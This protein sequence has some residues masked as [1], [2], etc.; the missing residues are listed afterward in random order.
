MMQ[1]FLLSNLDELPIN[2]VV[3]IDGTAVQLHVGS[4]GAI[5][6]AELIS[7]F[8]LI[9]MT[10]YL[11]LGFSNALEFEAG[12]AFDSARKKFVLSHWLP[13]VAN[14]ASAAAALEL[15]LNQVDVCQS[16]HKVP[17]PSVIKEP[18]RQRAEIRLRAQL[19]H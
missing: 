11:H 9:S 12:L 17:S 14:W 5:L 3:D 2:Q 6:S 1:Q 7:E 4:G 10:R 15:L 8:T 13:G 18:A 19:S 16:A